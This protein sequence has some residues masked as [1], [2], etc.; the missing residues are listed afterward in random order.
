MRRMYLDILGFY[1]MYI[2]AGHVQFKITELVW[3]GD[4]AK[5]T[6]LDSQTK[7]LGFIIRMVN[8]SIQ[9]KLR[10]IS[11]SKWLLNWILKDVKNAIKVYRNTYLYFMVLGCLDYSLTILNT[12]VQ[13]SKVPGFYCF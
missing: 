6:K 5:W 8:P 7:Y 12:D 10:N 11:H 9:K 1:E 13:E 2:G 4:S 3:C